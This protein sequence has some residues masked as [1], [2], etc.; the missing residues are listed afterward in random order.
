MHFKIKNIKGHKYLYLIQNQRVEGKVKQARQL[1]IGSPDKVYE[2]I[3][4]KRRL[5]IASFSFGKPV[6][7]LKAA[8]EVG[9]TQSLNNRIERKSMEGFTPPQ[10][11]LTIII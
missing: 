8:D 6:S 5:K 3:A 11:L 4:Q 2:L 1:C 9:L 7:L 10:Y